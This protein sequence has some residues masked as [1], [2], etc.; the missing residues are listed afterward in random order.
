MPSDGIIKSVSF[1]TL[2]NIISCF[3]TILWSIAVVIILV[4]GSTNWV[5]SMIKSEC[6]EIQ[7]NIIYLVLLYFSNRE[8]MTLGICKVESWNWGCRH[9]GQCLC[10]S[11]ARL[12]FDSHDVPHG[13]LFLVVRLAWVSRGRSYSLSENKFTVYWS[14]CCQRM[15]L[16]RKKYLKQ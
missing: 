6:A 3:V 1:T 10:Q 8:V 7:S 13:Y 4:A 11:N 2:G 16:Y 9:H 5:L 15:K 12:F 14:N